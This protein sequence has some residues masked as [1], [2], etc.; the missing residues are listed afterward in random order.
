MCHAFSIGL[1]EQNEPQVKAKFRKRFIDY[2]DKRTVEVLK[3]L[4]LQVIAF[5]VKG[6]AFCAKKTCRFYNA[7]WQ[8]DLIYSQIKSAKLCAKH[9]QVLNSMGRIQ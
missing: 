1:W 4:I 6:D 9:K 3:G 5:V 8:E 2:G 7:H